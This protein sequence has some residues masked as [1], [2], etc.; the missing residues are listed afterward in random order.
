MK[1]ANIYVFNVENFA[2]RI[3]KQIQQIQAAVEDSESTTFTKSELE[4]LLNMAE[5]SG[6]LITRQ[7]PWR[8]FAYYKNE[9]IRR[10]I[11]EVRAIEEIE[12][13]EQ[14]AG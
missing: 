6:T 13:D 4:Q 8:I 2:V 3:T 7:A 9:M 12:Q 5:D 1:K 10:G 14:A 11:L